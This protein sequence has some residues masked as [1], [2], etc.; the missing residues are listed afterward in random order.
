[1]THL[2]I[3]AARLLDRQHEAVAHVDAEPGPAARKGG[4]HADLHQ[5]T[6]ERGYLKNAIVA[7]T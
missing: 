3:V 1:M 5:M 6:T 7:F 2:D 4:D